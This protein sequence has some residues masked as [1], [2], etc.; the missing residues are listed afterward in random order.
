MTLQESPDTVPAG[1]VPRQVD[2]VLT[3]DLINTLSPG[4]GVTMTGVYKHTFDGGLNRHNQFP[5]FKT[6]IL[7]NSVHKSEDVR[8]AAVTHEMTSLIKTLPSRSD[9]IVERIIQ[10]V[11]PSIHGHRPIKEGIAAA[12]FGGTKDLQRDQE[13]KDNKKRADI[14][15]LL[16]GDPGCGKSQFLKF[17]EGVAPRAVFTTGK[18][19]SAVG[20]TASVQTDPVTREWTLAGGA[21]V[22]ADQ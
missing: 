5:T 3:A 19:A 16:V 15:I 8:Q 4:D 17:I 21:L 14:N 13:R 10:S 18:G 20:L 6:M 11:A 9:D 1:R 22:L 7:V 12:L 2:C